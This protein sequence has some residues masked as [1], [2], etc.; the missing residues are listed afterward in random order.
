MSPLTAHALQFLRLTFWFAA[1]FYI[2]YQVRKPDRFA[3]RFFTWVMN[4]SH[5]KL[6]DWGLQ[7]VQIGPTFTILDVGC[8]GGRTIEKLAALARSGKVYG[9]DYANGSV[10]ASSS[11]NQKLIQS[12]RVEIQLASV[13]RLPFPENKFDLVTAVETQYYW[14]DLPKAMQEI[15]RVLNPGGTLLIIAETYKK[16]STN[17]LQRPVMKILGSTNLGVEDQRELFAA[18]G[19]TAIQVFEDPQR[20]WICVTGTKPFASI[21]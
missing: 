21:A 3:G 18:G 11:R 16:G 17:Y 20:G 10:A 7:H 19:F 15:F 9:I 14:P 4:I 5:S 6:T 12:G 8:G 13:S 2:L 1:M